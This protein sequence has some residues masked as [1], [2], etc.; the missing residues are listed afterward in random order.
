MVGPAGRMKYCRTIVRVAAVLA[1]GSWAW[2]ARADDSAAAQALFNQ[3]R[4]AMAEQ[5]YAEACP[6]LEE[7]L[8]LEYG[9]GT[10]LNL[11]DCEEHAGKLASAWTKFLELASKARAAGQLERARIGR[12][13]A[14]A[15][16]PKLSN[17]VIEVPVDSRVEG[18]QV[19]RDGTPIGAAQWGTPIPADAGSHAI[20]ASAPGHRSWTA[21]VSVTDGATTARVTVPA[22]AVEAP[23][24]FPVATASAAAS[25]SEASSK[26]ALGASSEPA[27]SSRGLGLPKT[28]A[29]V[30]GAVGLAGVGVGSYFGLKSI[31]DH[32][33]VTSQSAS[34]GCK[35][36]GS[37]TGCSGPG[38][39][40]VVN[41]AGEARTAGTLSTAGFIVGGVA[42]AGAVVLWVAAPGME[43]G[44]AV[45]A[46][47][48]VGPGSMIVRG[49]W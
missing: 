15:L 44:A 35:T 49:Q 16:E 3:A 37:V 11:A 45:R 2:A 8:R 28:L 1:A 14:A 26:R 9:L 20:V 29:I 22:L 23:P 13:R 36:M 24:P 27:S 6:K 7:S 48:G 30:S 5:K 18:L 46:Q 38:A 19:Q 25:S 40:N 10:L 33:D 31:S 4:R 34:A 47:V 39:S 17:L 32:S 12:E 41:L 43:S 21:K 42:L